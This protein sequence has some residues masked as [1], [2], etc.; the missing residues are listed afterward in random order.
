MP[1]GPA[2]TTKTAS[3]TKCLAHQHNSPFTEEET[4]GQRGRGTACGVGGG[5]SS[6][7]LPGSVLRDVVCLGF[8]FSLSASFAFASVYAEKSPAPEQ[9]SEPE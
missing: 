1:P 9:E 4:K 6:E 7:G 8:F 2:S 3:S 5:C